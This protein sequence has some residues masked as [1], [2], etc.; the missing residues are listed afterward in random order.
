MSFRSIAA[1]L[2]IIATAAGGAYPLG[3]LYEQPLIPGFHP[4]DGETRKASQLTSEHPVALSLTTTLFTDTTIIDFEKRQ[5]S[6]V[7]YDQLGFIMWNYHYDELGG[8]LADRRN[9]AISRSWLQHSLLTQRAAGGATESLKLAWE[10]P[11]Q[12]PG[13]AQRVLGNDPPRL[14]INGNMKI[15]IGFEDMSVKNPGVEVQ[16][17]GT[18]FLFDQSNQF[19][20]SGS[21]GRLI[22]INISANSDGD[23][24][25]NNPLKNFKIEYKEQKSGELEDEVVQEVI[26]GYTGF[27]MPG[28]Q[29]SGYSESKEG[30][31]G[32]KV[33]SKFGPLMLTTIAS[34]EQGESQKLSA[35]N[36]GKSGAG[37]TT[38]LREGDFKK[39]R[40]FFLD[41][42]YITAWNRKFALSGGNANA[43]APPAVTKLEVWLQ[44][45]QYDEQKIIDKY[46]SENLVSFLVDEPAGKRFKFMRLIPERHYHLNRTEGHIRLFDSAN[47][48]DADVIA[49]SL[50]TEDARFNKGTSDST[51]YVIKPENPYENI[52]VNPARFR[53]MWRNVYDLSGEIED[54]TKFRLRLYH[55]DKDR[56]DTVKTIDN[57]YISEIMGLTDKNG[58]P[59]SG[60]QNIF[61]FSNREL[62]FPPFD[63]TPIGNE[64][65]ANPRLKHLRDTTIYRFGPQSRM[66]VENYVPLFSIET[67]GASKQTRWDLGFGVM[68]NTVRVTAD[69]KLLQ[70][71]V[72]YVFSPEIGTL[73][74]IS[75]LALAAQRIEIDYQRDAL[76]MPERKLFLGARAEMA[77]PFIS[78]KSLMGLSILYQNSDVAQI[79][80]RINMEPYS[81][82][83]L[84]FNTKLDFSPVWMTAAVNKIPLVKTDAPSSANV[85]FEI[86]H[87]RMNPN[88]SNEAY[89]DDFESSKQTM[90]VYE[91]YAS[92]FTAS[93]PPG[94]RDSLS[95]RP[96][97]WDQYWFSPVYSDSKNRVPY[98]SIWKRDLDDP[99]LTGSDAYESVLRWHVKPGPKSTELGSRYQR[100]WAGIMQSIPASQSDRKRDQYFELVLKTRDNGIGNGKLR[101]QIG[102]MR[103]DVC[104]AGLP[105]NDSANKE[106]TARFWREPNFPELDKGI[107]G[108]WDEEERYWVP[109]GSGGFAPLP[110]GDT[111]LE[112]FINDPSKDNYRL[113]D[114]YKPENYAF[115]SRL[116]NNGYSK[117]SEDLDNNGSV[118]TSVIEAFHEFVIDLTDPASPLI[119]T[120]A[121]KLKT[122]NG[123]RRYR[124]QLRDAYADH[125][126]LRRDVGIDAD[127]WINMRMVRLIWDDFDAA[128][129]SAQDSLILMGMQFV[130]NQWESV[131]DS[132]GVS[133]MEVS[134]ISTKESADYKRSIEREPLIKRDLNE[135]GRGR[136][137]EQSLRLVFSNLQEG[138]TALAERSFS[139]QPL[140]IASY[141][142]LTLVV[143]GKGPSSVPGQPLFNGDIKLVFRFGSD[144]TTYYEYTNVIMPEGNNRWNNHVRISLKD[145]S[146]LKLDSLTA[147]PND[148]LD[149]WS[150]D[151]MLHIRAPKGRQ[152]NFSNIT[153]MAVGVVCSRSSADAVTGELWVNELKVVGIKEFNGWSARLNLQTQFADFLNVTGGVNYEGGDFKTMTDQDITRTGDS[154][155]STNFSISTGL[156]KFMPR[157]WGVS[158]PIGGSITGSLTRPQLRPNSDI[159]LTDD[160]NKPDG[161]LDM[162]RDMVNNITG[163][164]AFSS[165][166]TM[167]E[168]FETQTYG[169]SFFLNYSKNSPSPNPAVDLLLE[170]LST[171][172]RYNMNTNL[173]KRGIDPDSS[174]D[175]QNT[176]T[177]HTYSGG[178]KYDLTPKDPPR[179]TRWK[180]FGETPAA[181]VPN[182]FKTLEFS[183]LPNRA[184]LDL[185]N[186]TYSTTRE[187]RREPE[188]SSEKESR[189]FDISHGLQLDFTPIRPLVDLSYSLNIT[190]NFPS[191]SSLHNAGAIGDFMRNDVLQRHDDPTWR[192]YYILERERSRSQKLKMTLNP[193]FVDWLTNSAEYTADYTGSL[194]TWGNDSTTDYFN[195]KVNTGVGF[196]STLN[197]SSL[198]PAAPDSGRIGLRSRL[199]KGCD[200]IGFN[201][202]TFSYTSNAN[203]DNRYLGSGYL[204]S[205]GEY[206]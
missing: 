13:W 34:S 115:V 165:D 188:L 40:Y 155:L 78:D 191:S 67:S 181:W 179:W 164:K 30:L 183:L 194:A 59:H 63:V 114:Y 185:A 190:R 103:E 132:L 17:G 135:T 156:D 54:I 170:R 152:P 39:Y 147:H 113:Y 51:L 53:L 49:I 186:A 73:E 149:Y 37:S 12:Y 162:A 174:A 163:Q 145:L 125:P 96:P 75:P 197:I 202:V 70:P 16:R 151:G 126:G 87:S 47:V 50:E 15:K 105:P 106:D 69:G 117:N 1:G 130:G 180:P 43:P 139:N 201:S 97:V 206:K 169:Q 79:V 27:S 94:V 109:N 21:V 146:R 131:K 93:P 33:A 120:T 61:N 4:L 138:E 92:W 195:G 175:F 166:S 112:E 176:D 52:S 2:A 46:G 178:I 83:L 68:E 121:D 85:E 110:R 62:I 60:R 20:I 26:A 123:W 140:K 182:Q 122:Q 89:V 99:F 31:F 10:L 108:L 80:P 129:L 25:M 187:S 200:L 19:T 28:T 172:F 72:D 173:V 14:S 107:D 76:F 100:A 198:L 32:I 196:N 74:I 189:V 91:S 23:M 18:G 167:A 29:L 205:S 36:S 3:V 84:D 161:F 77:L 160:D 6:F 5:I 119:D 65:F 42:A 58:E 9:F 199:R 57:V 111:L 142:S 66:M 133:K 56:G 90:M 48:R 171:T 86:A 41:T 81:K 150:G 104:I 127:D 184:N 192:N 157:D 137:H 71:N 134:V 144:S 88:S 177:S 22:N 116:Q 153:W 158:V 24:D 101:V 141:D 82:L 143:H 38:T 159:Y 95:L 124:L 55:V 8:Y 45:D 118:E 44:V 193:Q 203:L 136:Q 11:V 98:D 148:T 168:H 7:R 35:D 204:G 64:P 102:R 128:T 154:K